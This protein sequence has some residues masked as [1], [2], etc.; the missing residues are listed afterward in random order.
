MN[1]KKQPKIDYFAE[2]PKYDPL[3]A[4]PT[5]RVFQPPRGVAFGVFAS[6]RRSKYAFDASFGA[7]LVLEAPKC[8]V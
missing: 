7:A 1:I 2:Q 5:R 8:D 6:V 3:A 4:Q